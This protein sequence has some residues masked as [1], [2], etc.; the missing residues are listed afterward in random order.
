MAW[1]LCHVCQQTHCFRV[2]SGSQTTP[3]KKR[4]EITMSN[5]E[6]ETTS[7]VPAAE[8]AKPAG[9]APSGERV[10]TQAEV[11]SFLASEKRS[12]EKK[13]ADYE[14][15]KAKVAQF[16][17]QK[18]ASLSETERLQQQVSQLEE[19]YQASMRAKVAAEFGMPLE[20]VTGRTEEECQAQ[21]EAFKKILAEAKPKGPASSV[22]GNP[23]KGTPALNS[24]QLED[25]LRAKLGI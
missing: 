16:E 20:L 6:N 3:N 7:G 14:D 23:T 22:L 19:R 1:G 10:F 18:S 25:D 21:G 4:E 12:W 17:S 8:S 9:G 2:F 15:L 11:N 24:T 13:H 5:T